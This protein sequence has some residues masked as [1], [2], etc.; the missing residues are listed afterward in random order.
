MLDSRHLKLKACS[1]NGAWPVS[2]RTTVC[3]YS[4]DYIGLQSETVFLIEGTKILP[5][6]RMNNE[7]AAI[8]EHNEAP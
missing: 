7:F 4:A 2:I 6:C 5:G 8:A 3:G 1:F